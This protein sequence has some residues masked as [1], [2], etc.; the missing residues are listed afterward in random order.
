MHFQT[1]SADAWGAALFPR[2]AAPPHSGGR[3]EST[4]LKVMCVKTFLVSRKSQNYFTPQTK[5][6]ASNIGGI[7]INYLQSRL[8][9]RND[10]L[11]T[12]FK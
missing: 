11:A 9:Q 2:A 12:H 7:F 1:G 10:L 4:E 3:D 8:S 6:A 5:I